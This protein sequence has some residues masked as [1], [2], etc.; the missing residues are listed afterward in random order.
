MTQT[1][2]DAVEYYMLHGMDKTMNKY[3]S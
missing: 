2:A 3:N 1:I